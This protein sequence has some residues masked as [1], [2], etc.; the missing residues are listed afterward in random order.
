MLYQTFDASFVLMCN[1]DKVVARNLGPKCKRDKTCIWVPKSY[2]TNLVEPT[3]VGYLKPKL[4]LPCR[5]M[6]PGA[7]AGSL[8]ADAQ[9][10]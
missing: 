10:T 8:I 5:F 9:T 7:Q 4:K 6:H 2:V 1:N 3:R